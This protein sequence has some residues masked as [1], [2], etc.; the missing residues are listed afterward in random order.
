VTVAGKVV[1][2]DG[3]PVAEGIVIGRTYTPYSYESQFVF[4]PFNGGAPQLKVRDGRVEVPG[5]DPEKPYTFHVFDREHLLG[6]TVELSGRSAVDGPVTIRLR[7]CGAA[8]VRYTHD[9]G[10]PV[11]GHKPELLGLVLTPG[12]EFGTMGR[13]NADIVFQVQLDRDERNRG[14]ETDADGRITFVALIPGAR[15][16]FLDQEFTAEAGRTIGLRDVTIP[17]PDREEP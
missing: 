2:P 15:Y 1:G 8:T 14:Q 7:E 6:A 11:A 16:R 10:T 9:D 3:A 5:C 13:I 12:A 17:R 4:S